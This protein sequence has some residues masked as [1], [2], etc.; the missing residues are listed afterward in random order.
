MLI[1]LAPGDPFSSERNIS[2]EIREQMEINYHLHGSLWEK[3]SSYMYRLFHGDLG[4]LIQYKSITVN[5]LVAQTLPDSMILGAIAYFMALLLGTLL[6][7]VAAMNHN[8]AFDRLAMGFALLGISTP[9]FITAP[10][11]V[12]LF[13][14]K[15]G[16]LPVAGW[17][18]PDQII[19][20][21]ICLSLPFIASIARLV[22][23]S[24]LEVLQLDF[25]RTARAKGLSESDVL[26]QHALKVAILPLISYSGPA[27]AGI[28]TGSIVIEAIFGIPGIGQFFLKSIINREPFLTAGV[29]LVY[30]FFLIIF[31]LIADLLYM[32]VDRRIEME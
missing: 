8:R 28:L 29:V 2:P 21:A 14:L 15:L 5:Q 26:F 17:G 9:S 20:P 10:L 27:L 18:S 4:P 13:A 30:G 19:L 6:G 3:Y 11:L 12:M 25:I 23:G 24:L 1:I 16:L 22:R 7:T 31:N 32:V